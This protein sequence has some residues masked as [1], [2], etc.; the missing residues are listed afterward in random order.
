MAQDLSE[1]SHSIGG[2][3]GSGGFAFAGGFAQRSSYNVNFALGGS[4]GVGGIGEAVT[5][6]NTGQ[7][8]TRGANSTAILAQSIGGG[9]GNGGFSVATAIGVGGTATSV[10][11][12][13]SIGGS[14]GTGGIGGT[15][16]VTNNGLLST[17]GD[18]AYGIQA[19]SIGGGGG[20][21]GGTIGA[22]V[23]FAAGSPGNTVN[24]SVAVGGNGGSG[25]VGGNVTIDQTVEFRQ[26]VMVHTASSLRALAEAVASV[27]GPIRWPLRSVRPA[28]FRYVRRP[29][30]APTSIS[31]LRWAE[32]AAR[33]MTPARLPLPTTATSQ[34]R[35]TTPVGILARASAAVVV[36]A[37]TGR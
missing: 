5:V 30:A 13:V 12:G 11:M 18:G 1:F 2:G 14:G 36:R 17:Q 4:G 10:N 32:T 7:I 34:P 24:A 16:N 20:N 33:A 8:S 37:V 35:A 6:N 19:Q 26:Q 22:V 25:N 29:V 27:G 28:V 9:G 23:G 31:R 15:V 21:G 3:G